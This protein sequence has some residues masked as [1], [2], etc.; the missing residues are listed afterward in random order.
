MLLRTL[1]AWFHD[2]KLKF[3][4]ITVYLS[5]GLLAPGVW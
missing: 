3:N 1:H 2:I 4:N 5:E